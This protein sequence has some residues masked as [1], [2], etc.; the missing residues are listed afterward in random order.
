MKSIKRIV[1]FSASFLFGVCVWNNQTLTT[2]AEEL[3][4]PGY[5]VYTTT[6]DEVVDTWYG[7]SKGNY[8][9]NGIVGLVEAGKGKV[10]VS[11]TTNARMACDKVK[12]AVYLDESTNG[13]SSFGTI[14]IYHYQEE[15]TTS[16]YGS[17]SNIA[18]TSGRWYMVR[19][20]HTVI[21]GST[22]ESTDTQTSAM[23]VS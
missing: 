11:G 10:N 9:V 6:E 16:C 4:P 17:K 2:Q 14:G 19:G 18:V 1:L 22:I 5:H 7:I 12:V 13:G 8:L 3:T 20:V 21:E 15:N 23:K